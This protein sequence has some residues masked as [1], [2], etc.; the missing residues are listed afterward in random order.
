MA[1]KEDFWLG[2]AVSTNDSLILR[3]KISCG[4]LLLVWLYITWPTLKSMGF[5]YKY[6]EP[7]RHIW[8]LVP[9]VMWLF[10]LKRST[11]YRVIPTSSIVGLVLL[12][13]ISC[14]WI[15]ANITGLIIFEQ[16]CTILLLRSIVYVSAGYKATKVLTFPFY[17]ALFLIPVGYWILPEINKTATLFL[18]DM[19][20]YDGLFISQYNKILFTF[21]GKV[22]ITYAFHASTYFLAYIAIGVLLAYFTLTRFFRRF[23]A[24][25]FTSNSKAIETI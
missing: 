2:T 15:L 19:L 22:D 25:E 13:L 7:D 6:S 8:A 17:F 3:S 1:D 18:I 21:N 4:V 14:G 24:S 23:L 16:I 20:S 9:T 11:L 10:F 12:I 5:F